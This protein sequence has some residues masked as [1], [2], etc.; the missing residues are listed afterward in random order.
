[1]FAGLVLRHSVGVALSTGF[2]SR[3]FRLIH[4]G[5]GLMG[6]AVTGIARDRVLAVFAQLPIGDYV[7]RD[8]TV[9]FHAALCAG[10]SGNQGPGYQRARISKSHI[11]L[12]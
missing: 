8:F 12:A 5:G 11:H 9:A 10:G 3:D 2:G 1:V 7:L 6:I 4:I